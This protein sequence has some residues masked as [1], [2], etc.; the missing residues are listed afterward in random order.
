MPAI[1][2]N[3]QITKLDYSTKNLRENVIIKQQSSKEEL[4]SAS[5]ERDVC[6]RGN[7]AV[8]KE[9]P[10]LD[11]ESIVGLQEKKLGGCK[12][13]RHVDSSSWH[14]VL[15]YEI[16]HEP[17]EIIRGKIYEQDVD[18]QFQRSLELYK[19]SFNKYCTE[20]LRYQLEVTGRKAVFSVYNMYYNDLG[21]LY[22]RTVL[23][24]Y[25]DESA[26]NCISR[27]DEFFPVLDIFSKH[28]DPTEKEAP[29]VNSSYFL[30]KYLK[31]KNVANKFLADQLIDKKLQSVLK[32]V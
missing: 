26:I 8:T 13:V 20:T 28:E 12:R 27:T 18:A 21:D 7:N 4:G 19:S 5:L 24:V 17:S 31:Q 14:G 22:S 23:E 15:K 10:K 3:N 6:S 9:P 16:I 29:I 32:F 25:E 2:T 30:D 11:K 1:N